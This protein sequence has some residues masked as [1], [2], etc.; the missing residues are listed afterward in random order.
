MGVLDLFRLDRAGAEVTD[1]ATAEGR[2]AP[3]R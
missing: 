3:I 2:A 1:T